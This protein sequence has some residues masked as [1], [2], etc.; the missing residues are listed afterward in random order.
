MAYTPVRRGSTTLCITV[1]VS[2]ELKAYPYSGGSFGA[3]TGHSSNSFAFPGTTPS[4]SS[5]S[6]TDAT[7][8]IIWAVESSPSSVLY[9][10]NSSLMELYDSTQAGSRDSLPTAITFPTPTIANG[11]V[12]VPTTTGVTFFGILSSDT[13]SYSVPPSP[14]NVPESGQSGGDSVLTTPSDRVSF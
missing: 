10:F 2:Q 4:V 8:E 9:A 3:A 5:D 14:Y 6:L 13:C 1:T 12:Y 7:N 11:K